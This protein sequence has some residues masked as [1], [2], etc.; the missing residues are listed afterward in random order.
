MNRPVKKITIF[1]VFVELD[2]DG[3]TILKLVLGWGY[4]TVFISLLSVTGGRQLL[5][6]HEDSDA[7]QGR[8]SL[9]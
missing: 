1:I 6:G 5:I 2:V 8:E 3:I 9:D 7:V 4:W